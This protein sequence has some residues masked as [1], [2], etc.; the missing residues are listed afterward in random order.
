MLVESSVYMGSG[1][2]SE[3]APVIPSG[4]GDADLQRRT[5]VHTL[6]L[7]HMRVLI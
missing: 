4:A 6:T 1:F 2:S 3:A 5:R 7:T